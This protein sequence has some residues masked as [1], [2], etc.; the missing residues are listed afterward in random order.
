MQITDL[1]I[2]NL[3]DSD[4]E[5]SHKFRVNQ[6]STFVNLTRSVI[7]SQSLQCMI[8]KGKFL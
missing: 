2:E 1:I 4:L 5:S 6:K 3:T 8:E 7:C